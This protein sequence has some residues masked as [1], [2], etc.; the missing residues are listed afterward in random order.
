[1]EKADKKFGNFYVM[2]EAIERKIWVRREEEEK[3]RKRER[4]RHR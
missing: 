4:Y 3:R 2:T 1:M